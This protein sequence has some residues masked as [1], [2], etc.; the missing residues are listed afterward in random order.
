MN[1]IFANKKVHFIYGLWIAVNGAISVLQTF[2][3]SFAVGNILVAIQNRDGQLLSAILHMFVLLL[4]VS[5]LKTLRRGLYTMIDCSFQEAIEDR[6][7]NSYR[8]QKG[9]PDLNVQE[10]LN[11][12]RNYPPGISQRFLGITESLTAVYVSGIA[13]VL[14]LRSENT[15]LMAAI[16]G[17]IS[18]VMI[19][20]LLLSKCMLKNLSGAWN[21]RV[22]KASDIYQMTWE[23]VN[24]AEVSPFLNMDPIH[25]R[26]VEK[27]NAYI[28]ALKAHK[29]INRST[30]SLGQGLKLLLFL[31]VGMICTLLYARHELAQAEIY[32]FL[33]ILIR[34]QNTAF[35]IPELRV[36]VLELKTLW[37]EAEKES[38][39]DFGDEIK[40]PAKPMQTIRIDCK[41]L[42]VRVANRVLLTH[43]D[44]SFEGGQLVGIAGRSG[45]GK[46]SLLRALLG[47]GSENQTVIAAGRPLNE[48]DLEE[49][50]KQL[51]MISKEPVFFSG[52]VSE[53]ILCGRCV[54][55][56][57]LKEIL[58]I[59]RI[60]DHLYEQSD[61]EKLSSGEKQKIAAARTLLSDKKIL[62]FDE[63]LSNMDYESKKSIV[64]CLLK[65][66]KQKKK[67]ILIVSHEKI[68]LESTEKL[69]FLD[70]QQM[71]LDTYQRL[72]DTN[73][74]FARMVMED[75]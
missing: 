66:C 57:E 4:T 68:I 33:L 46:T 3:I 53:N 18:V 73:A 12:F 67:L 65:L 30:I 43:I 9:S 7:W 27:N 60:S 34:L 20:Y 59:C 71:F 17:G 74:E 75:E 5:V 62:I 11:H 50:W 8:S 23:H 10:K 61:I 42:T 24:N 51:V 44:V 15:Y 2:L 47:L 69:C 49:Y 28:K 45:S 72:L 58:N 40:D 63:A 16:L 26:Y 64:A 31:A 38:C 52:T 37:R 41:D 25:D 19:A 39:I 29:R 55:S 21:E 13:A 6:M 1:K 70:G 14:Y 36:Q 32:V 54:D 35:L 48:W 56:S 22:N